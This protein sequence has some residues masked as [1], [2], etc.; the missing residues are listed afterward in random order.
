MA[1]LGAT[2]S[3]ASERTFPTNNI[4]F[5]T[6]AVTAS[7]SGTITGM[8]AFVKS[9]DVG[10]EVFRIVLYED[11]AGEPVTFV[12]AS[13][14][15]TVAPGDTEWTRKDLSASGSIVSGHDYW[16]GVWC[17]DTN[18][19]GSLSVSVWSSTR[20]IGVSYHSTNSPGDLGS[21]PAAGTAVIAAYVTYTADPPTVT[22]APIS[23][24]TASSATSGG[25]ITDAG[26][27]SVTAYGV[28]WNTTGSPTTADSH[29]HDE[30]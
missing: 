14:E 7:E 30:P 23:N 3:Q 13:V 21:A 19:Q 5:S 16:L 28:C 1:T 25:T 12:A 24:I 2:T 18:A 20:Y 10:S 8:S 17:G 9:L 4:L 6:A 29:T 26:G 27:S 22:T 11:V 15:G